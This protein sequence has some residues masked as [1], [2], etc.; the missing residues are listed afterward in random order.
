L[1]S[2]TPMSIL[3]LLCLAFLAPFY[4]QS[5]DLAD[6]FMQTPH[7]LF[8]KPCVLHVPSGSIVHH[9][10]NVLTI[11]YLNGSISEY[12]EC[13]QPPHPYA[14]ETPYWN[15]WYEHIWYGVNYAPWTN[16]PLNS[17][18][19]FASVSFTVPP[20]PLNRFGNSESPWS[21]EPSLSFWI[22]IQGENNPVLQPCLD[23]NVLSPQ[24]FDYTSWNCCPQ[25]Y[26]VH[27]DSILNLNE[28]QQLQG[29]IEQTD[30]FVYN[31]VS[32]VVGGES[33]SLVADFSSYPGWSADW[34]EVQV[35]SYYVTNCSQ[36][37][38]GMITFSDVTFDI[39][40]NNMSSIPW[41]QTTEC[42]LTSC[43]NPAICNGQV[44]SSPGQVEIGYQSA[45][46]I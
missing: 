20:E 25:G 6:D 36:F 1:Y 34:V 2:R 9:G 24:A 5:K 42:A 23:F 16:P 27:S 15:G 32:K 40:G 38:A 28:G 39:G 11:E 19:N 3:W 43:P 18:C 33:V 29:Y 35:E 8:Y 13:K 31:I 30:E 22:G 37:P 21:R 14:G 12:T 46:D 41:T 45:E 17:N 26:N 44:N 10:E 4:V 7:G